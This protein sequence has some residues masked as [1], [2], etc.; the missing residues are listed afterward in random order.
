MIRFLS[1]V[2]T[3]MAVIVLLPLP[4]DATCRAR[5]V[6]V[7]RPPVVLTP[8]VPVV[9]AFAVPVYSYQAGYAGHSYG[10]NG[11]GNGG[12]EFQ[13]LIQELRLLK[14]EIAT[15]RQQGN[16]PQRF[17]ST[18][19]M[20]GQKCAACH[21]Q[22]TALKGGKLVLLAGGRFLDTLTPEQRGK[23][24]EQVSLKRTMPKGGKLTAEER[25]QILIEIIADQGGPMPPAGQK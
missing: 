20:A 1:A 16:G 24:I 14:A 5:A 18:V 9:T 11:N 25:E 23:V 2:L 12:G 10:A 8:F 15:L 6:V 19:S 4:A 7:H 22:G 17:G 13:T 3:I 21:D